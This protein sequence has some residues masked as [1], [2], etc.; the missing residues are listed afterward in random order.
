M[1]TETLEIF[2]M[3]AVVLAIVILV[4]YFKMAANMASIKNRLDLFVDKYIDE[5]EVWRCPKCNSVNKGTGYCHN[6][7]GY[8]KYE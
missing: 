4:V 6:N 7:C 3:I 5:I 8:E 1:E 2:Y